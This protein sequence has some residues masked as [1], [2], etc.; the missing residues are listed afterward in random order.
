[1]KRVEIKKGLEYETYR[2][3][4]WCKNCGNKW[5]EDIKKGEEVPRKTNCP[6]C[7]TFN[8]EPIV[9]WSNL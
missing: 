4:F 2:M 6:R 5:F 1:M 3:K 9:E 7:E 8:G